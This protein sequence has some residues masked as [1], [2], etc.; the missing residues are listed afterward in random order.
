MRQI[1]SKNTKPELAVRKALTSL[2]YRYRLKSSLPGKPDIVFKGRK[3]AI[4][5]HGCFWHQHGIGCRL[6]TRE[7]KSNSTYWVPKLRRNKERDEAALVALRDMGWQTLV[8]WECE[9]DDRQALQ[10]L[11]TE[12]LNP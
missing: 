6:R 7:P 3:K 1:R 12:F 10:A 4:F 2:G 5:V 8:I 9:A 11:L